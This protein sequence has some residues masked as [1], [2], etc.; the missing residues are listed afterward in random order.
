[1]DS[2]C[3]QVSQ[4]YWKTTQKKIQQSE[5]EGKNEVSDPVEHKVSITQDILIESRKNG[6]GLTCPGLSSTK[7]GVGSVSHHGPSR[8][9]PVG[10][11]KKP[12][13]PAVTWRR[14][15]VTIVVVVVV[16]VVAP[17]WN[18]QRKT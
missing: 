18:E 2:T 9:P 4:P 8:F 7:P 16:V 3:C 11:Q 13:L 15:V 6:E 12:S 1:M 17:K 5:T 14:G 10:E